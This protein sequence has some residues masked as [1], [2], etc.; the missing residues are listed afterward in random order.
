MQSGSVEPGPGALWLTG[1]FTTETYAS[2]VRALKV[3]D[4]EDAVKTVI[5]P[6]DLIW[7]IVGDS[8]KIEAGVREL[9]LGEFHRLSA[10]GH[11]R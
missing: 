6:E 10:E 5:H 9:N 2:K 3:S 1:R 11:P 8:S 7:V 4:L